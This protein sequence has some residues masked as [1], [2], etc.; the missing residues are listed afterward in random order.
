MTNRVLSAISIAIAASVFTCGQDVQT[1][2]NVDGVTPP[3][4]EGGSP[5][6]TYAL[7]NLEQIN[8]YNGSISVLVPL[9][10]VSGRGTA[11][12]TIAVP[13]ERRWTVNHSVNRQTQEESYNPSSPTNVMSAPSAGYTSIT[14]YSPGRMVMRQANAGTLVA[15]LTCPIQNGSLKFVAGPYLTR[16]VWI[17]PDGSETT[18]RDLAYGGQP[19]GPSTF[20]CPTMLAFSP[21]NR[22]NV[23]TSSDGSSM[24]F[25]SDAAVSDAL[26][27]SSTNAQSGTLL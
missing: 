5:S 2:S 1:A 22:G 18:L 13:I 3:S 17:G 23:F 21:A 24:T 10:H 9:Y 11:G 14:R 16:A 26:G 12:Y 8:Y 15:P 25:I 19:I 7:T 27:G 4:I 20:D 6:G